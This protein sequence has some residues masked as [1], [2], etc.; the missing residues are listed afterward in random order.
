[1]TPYISFPNSFKRDLLAGKRLIGLWSS[2]ASP[3][4]MEVLGLAG[5][6]WLLMDAE[7]SPNDPLTFVPQLMAL[8]DSASAPVARPSSNDMVELKRL[9]DIGF[10]NF[11]IPFVETP[12]QARYAVAATRYP[13]Q[14]VRGVS[15]SQRSNRYGTV[16]DY[17]KGINNEICVLVQIESRLGMSHVRDIAKVEGVDGIFIGP[18]DLAAAMGHL[19]NPKHP[20]VQEAI[21]HLFG[22]AK[23]CGKASGILAPVEEDARRYIEWGV[24]FIAVGSD[25]GV[26]KNSTQALRDR[27]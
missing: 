23:A 8:K 5:Y 16:P 22:E 10:Y 18:S 7:H 6:D 17:M 1:M 14:G 26:F 27:F 25:L 2:L 24:G 9:L 4:A 12:E 3:I 19:G 13:P 20:E 15:V 11:L 21:K